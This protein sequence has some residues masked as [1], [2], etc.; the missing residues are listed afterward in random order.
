MTIERVI[1]VLLAVLVVVLCVVNVQYKSRTKRQRAIIRGQ[2]RRVREG[3]AN[4]ET[5]SQFGQMARHLAHDFKQPATAISAHLYVLAK[6]LPTGSD[7]AKEVTVI[8]KE[9]GN[10]SGLMK[11]FLQSARQAEVES[12]PVDVK[13]LVEDVADLMVALLAEEDIDVRS[14]VFENL[15]LPGQREELKQMLIDLVRR[16]A[17]GLQDGDAVVVRGFMAGRSVRKS[18][19]EAICL[20]VE[21]KGHGVPPKVGTL[22]P[23]GSVGTRESKT[24]V[25]AA[26]FVI[27]RYGGKLEIDSKPGRGNVFRVLLPS[28]EA[29]GGMKRK[30]GYSSPS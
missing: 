14:E 3:L 19:T 21:G 13:G 30:V 22:A 24:G 2:A 17:E 29:S 23:D 10:L 11:E 26:E 25:G 6:L 16:A 4:S 15:V 28:F 7:A 1:I 18:A 5:L 20:E 9:I 12:V 8:E 27:F